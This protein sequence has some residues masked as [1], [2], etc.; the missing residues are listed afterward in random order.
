MLKSALWTLVG[1]SLVLSAAAASATT[2][3]VPADQPTIQAGINAAANNDTVLVSPGNYSG[4]LDLGVKRVRVIGSGGANSTLITSSGDGV[5]FGAGTDSATSLEGFT[6]SAP[7]IAVNSYGSPLIQDNV[8]HGASFAMYLHESGSIIRRNVLRDNWDGLL[9]KEA[10]L[11]TT[12][13]IAG[14]LF[15]RNSGGALHIET[16]GPTIVEKNTFV[17]NGIVWG[18]SSLYVWACPAVTILNNTIVNNDAGLYFRAT[19]SGTAKNNIIAFNGMTGVGTTTT[20]VALSYNDVFANAT[21]YS[22]PAQPG[23]GSISQ[24][25]AL[26]DVNGGNYNLNAGSPCINAGDP[27]AQYNDSDGSR[28]DMGAYPFCDTSFAGDCDGDGVANGT[29]NCLA[30][31]NPDQ[32]DSDADGRGDACDNCTAVAN[33]LQQDFDGDGRG[34][35]CDNCPL[36]INPNQQDADGDGKGEVCDNC[37]TDYNP[38][39]SDADGDGIGDI[40]DNCAFDSANDADHDG[41]CESIDNCPT[42]PN[43]NQ[44]DADSDGLGDACDNCPINY[45]PTQADTDGDGKADAC[46]NCPSIYN[47]SQTD[48]DHDG[49]GNA[50]DA[51]PFD[52]LNDPDA[53][54][55]CNTIDNC[56]A[57]FNPDQADTNHNGIGEAC[58]CQCACHGDPACDS[59][60]SDILDVVTTIN[61]AFRGAAA[62]PDPNG[63]CPRETTDMDCTGATD[64]LDVV[65]VINVAFRGADVAAEY[66][67]PC[68]P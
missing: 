5:R 17:G 10:S 28:N 63:F 3:H 64:V 30:V 2:I 41:V 59:V 61:V 33:P 1:C 35:A 24:N 34:D 52:P 49:I 62:I 58:E 56:P 66:C 65:K 20:L 18:T 31:P 37:P 50:C 4:P 21:D 51:C 45:N 9:F 14:N 67:N 57:V 39:Q 25:P 44:A 40:C 55:V 13:V 38:S 46:D 16:P 23:S 43:P 22:G 68:S 47:S 6:I 48:S 60:I 53:D 19:A 42:V 32:A 8:I 27:A 15:L 54:G 7:N 11:T 12:T 26:V 29:D 36:V